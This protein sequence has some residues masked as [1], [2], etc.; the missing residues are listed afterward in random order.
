VGH[1]RALDKQLFI[2]LLVTCLGST[3]MAQSVVT[4]AVIGTLTDTG[5]QAVATANVVARNVDTKREATA[6][7]DDEG[8]FRIVGLQ[9]GHYIIEV[10]GPGFTSFDVANAVVE[11]GRVTTV[12][13]SL[14]SHPALSG[15]APTRLSGINT[16]RQGLSVNLNQTSFNELP[17]NGRRWSNFAILAPATALDGP[18]GEVSF[19]GISSLFNKTTVD[20]GDN[21]QAFFGNERGG[22][23]IAYGIGLASIREVHINVSNY[24]AEYG[25]AA[26]GTINAI[27]KSGTN[28]LH[29]SAFFYDR[30]NKW[31][32]RN[33]RGF[34][35]VSID[36][37]PALVPLKPVDTR[38]Q[39]GGT[40]GGPVLAD[41]LFF[42]AS[43]DQQR[44]NFPAVSTTNDPG[45]FDTVD[46]GTTGAGLKAPPALTDAQ[47]DSTL[48]FLKS[49]TGEVPRRGDQTIYTPRVDWHMNSRHT[50]SATYNRLRWNSP[51]GIDTAP[52]IN[53]G[54]ASFGDD[55]VEI[56]WITVGVMSAMRSR[57]VNELRGQLGR[58][59]EF[60]FSQTPAPGEP[61]TGPHGKPP[62]ITLGGGIIF[63]T[64]SALDARA[65][66]DE[67]Q[68]QFA[69]TITLALRDH[70]I[71]TGFDFSRVSSL[72]DTLL[73]EEGFYNYATL[74]DFI[75]DY[76]NFAAAG[77]LRA[78]GRV[79]SNPARIA[80]Q[81][82]GN[83]NQ[84]FGR[85]A[86]GFTTNEYSFF[87]QDEYRLLSRL[88]L[89]LGLR[90]E[91][92]QLP[93]PQVPNLL[94]NAAGAIFGPEQTQSFPS[95][96]NDFE[97][98]LGFAYDLRGTGRTTIRG[99]YGIYHGR[100]PNGT[101]S[102]VVNETGAADS[103]STFQVNPATG[104]SAAPVFPNT[105]TGPPS[106]PGSPTIVVFDPNMQRPSVRQ[107]D[108]VLEHDLGSNTVLSAAYLFSAGHD[109]PTFI[110][111]NL[112]VPTS[113][114]YTIIGGDFDGQT[115]TVSPFFSGPRPD[116]RFGVI[117]AVRSLIKSKY[118]A[119]VVQ[120]NQR[121]T[122]GCQFESSYTLSKATDNGQSSAIFPGS[123]YPSNP[124][125][126]SADQGP[127]DVHAR[128]KLTATAVWSSASLA[129]NHGL[130]H[131]ILNGFTVSTIFFA[132]SGAPYSAGAGGNAPGGLRAGITGG[133]LP[134]LSRFPLFSRN[135][136]RMPKIVNVDLRISRRFRITNEVNLEILGEAFNLLNRTQVTELNTRMYAPGGTAA[137]STLTFDP[138]FQT[139][140]AAGNDVVRERQLQF[141][142]RMEF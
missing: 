76:T 84:S 85:A 24:P 109:L 55:F 116:S 97:P 14:N 28:T 35:S 140:R 38:Y 133:G 29:G 71:K 138:S 34:Q 63:G 102:H 1:R 137:A 17:N 10:G 4:G 70:V 77:A 82:Y 48:V 107:S 74:N 115:L 111:V 83:F 46:R 60:Q 3:A 40:V 36:G 68:W 32:A 142:I 42:F 43:Y 139:V 88:A 37:V 20:G 78:A 129:S 134:G 118:H 27:T 13:I 81:C 8:R 69:D 58:D 53:R 47:I 72:E 51:G 64:R 96:K 18:F 131:R 31:G 92:Q 101:I 132:K 114:T 112:P 11:V 5:K 2:G 119:V 61:L 93:K 25:G 103:Q 95:D 62:T 125:D 99:G 141:A 122:K 105:F 135:A 56:D 44:R 126:V 54:R 23:R 106:G 113:R 123:N 86:F 41:R 90:Y 130:A 108:L 50:L 39:F 49:L 65:Y 52:T 30:D 110:D 19:R 12:D 120:L 89:N 80:G 16:T 59:H 87:V 79:C 124:L 104:A 121:L 94:S 7:S 15:L 22:R 66:P 45:Y 91:Y 57:M 100:I 33:P 6:T 26:G 127:S 136:F 73:Y 21:N 67:K 9:P 98:R 75:I 117:T 128:H